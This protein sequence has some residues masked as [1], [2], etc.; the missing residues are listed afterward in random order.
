MSSL[1]P[2]VVFVSRP[3]ELEM[4]LT[5]HA[6]RGQVKFFLER[7]EQ[8][9]ETLEARHDMQKAAIQEARLNVPE[10]WIST[11]INRND[12]DR[13]L[14]SEND[15]VVAIGQDGLV[16]NLAKYLNGQPVIGLTSDPALSEGILT[17]YDPGQLKQLFKAVGSHTAIEKRTMVEARLEDNQALLALNEIFIGHHS[18]QSA[19]YII[20]SQGFSE[21]HSS[22]GIIVSSGTGITGWA[23]SI[24][25]ATNQRVDI[26]PSDK[27]AFFFAREPWPSK[28]SSIELSFGEVTEGVPLQVTSRMNEGGV[29]FADG[30][31]QDFIHFDWGRNAEIS[32]SKRTLNLVN[33]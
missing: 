29:I 21:F 1:S 20:K 33:L 26:K 12:L 19:K 3:T 9:I 11:Y 22:S 6:T 32:I 13:F 27:Q 23:K 8:S 16:A 2:R 14:F 18:H 31:E 25:T 17:R 7:R 30:I 4:L 5:R 24:L 10:D 28:N 15:I